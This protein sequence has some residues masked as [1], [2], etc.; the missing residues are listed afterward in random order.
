MYNFE[1]DDHQANQEELRQL[2]YSLEKDNYISHVAPDAKSGLYESGFDF[3]T[4]DNPAV[5][6]FAEWVKG[7]F[8]Q[9]AA[10]A[11]KPYWPAG[12]N[13]GIDIHE[14]WCHITRNGGYHEMHV[15][16]NSSWS[17]IYYL[18]PGDADPSKKSG[19]NRFFTP[20]T[21]MYSDAGTAWLS[22]TTSID[23]QPAE[24]V[25]IVFPSWLPHSAVAY[26]GDADRIVI[27]LNCRINRLP[28]VA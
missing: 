5:Q 17:A 28:D 2:C 10:H 25:L 23:I 16:P 4:V 20:R 12:M 24:G 13:V 1:W 21:N 22:S 27:A 15:H 8:F 18:A 11:N 14:S 26:H 3:I 9:A 7:C 6:S 19:V